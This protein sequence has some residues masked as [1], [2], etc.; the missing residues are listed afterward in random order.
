MEGHRF[1]RLA[2]AFARRTTRRLVVGAGA[3]AI[4]VSGLRQEIPTTE[5]AGGSFC[6]TLPPNQ[7]ISKHSCVSTACGTTEGCVCVQTPGHVV[8]CAA[9]FDPATDCPRTDECSDRRPCGQGKFCAKVSKCCG[10]R[11]RR[12]CLRPCPA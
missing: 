4:G 12:L 10:D 8:R 7:I 6:R 3:L 5:A 9:R 1:D 11:P 2:R